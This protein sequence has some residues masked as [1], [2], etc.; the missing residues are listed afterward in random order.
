MRL[1]LPAV[2]NK[3]IDRIIYDLKLQ[4]KLIIAFSVIMLIPLLLLGLTS[5]KFMQQ[6]LQDTEKQALLQSMRQLNN[7]VDYFLNSYLNATTMLL[8]NYELQQALN[9][10]TQNLVDA[11]DGRT[12]VLQIVQQIQTGLALSESSGGPNLQSNVTVRFY[13]T[14]TPFA[15]YMGDILPLEDVMNEDWFSR[16]YS[17]LPIPV[18]QSKVFLNGQPNIVLDRKI[19]DF[20]VYA[21]IG[22]MR[23]FIPV[24]VLKNFVERNIPAGIYRYFYVDDQFQD[25]LDVGIGPPDELLTAI[26]SPRL[27][28]GIEHDDP[29]QP[30]VY[31]GD[32]HILPDRLALHFCRLHRRHQRHQPHCLD[33]HAAICRDRYWAMHRH[34]HPGLPFSH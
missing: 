26:K 9:Q 33:G 12:K 10:K 18:W 27:H 13:I 4:Y 28:L 16:V 2:F 22:V 8:R 17:P 29:E 24:S 32:Y 5:A 6:T 19:T 7:S 15:S 31:R 11:I 25:V 1:K 3:I 34:L 30:G 20:T 21:P 23:V 14:N